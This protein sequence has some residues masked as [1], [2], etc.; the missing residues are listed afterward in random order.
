MARKRQGASLPMI[1]F[2]EILRLYEHGCNQSEIARSCLISR[3]AVRDYLKRAQQCRLSYEQLSSLSDSDIQQL[4]GKG[5]RQ[6]SCSKPAID[7]ESIHRELQHKGVTLAL[8]WM[9]GK[10]RGDW[11]YSYSGFCR[12]YRKWRAQQPV[13]MRQVHK[14]GDKLFVDFCGLTV[15]VKAPK[16]GQ[17]IEAEIFVGCLGASNYT[18]AEAV[19]SQALEHWIGAHQRLLRFFGGVPNKIVPDNLKS[20]VNDPCRYEPGINRTYAEFAEHYDVVVL[21]ARPRAPRDKAK[22]EKA[23]QEVERQILAPLRH[24]SFSSFSALNAA[25]SERLERL[26]DRVMRSYGVSR[27]ALFEELDQP[28]LKALPAQTFEYATWKKAKVSFD[29]HIEVARHYYSVPYA[30]IRKSVMVKISESLIEVFY[31]NQ[32][33]CV[34]ERSSTPFQHSTHDEHMPPEHY[35]YKTQSREKYLVWAAQVGPET[36]A[37]VDAIFDKKQY[38]EQAFR[39]LQGVKHLA[40]TYGAVRLEA[41]CKKANILGIASQ[42]RLSS[43]LKSGLESEPLP[44]QSPQLV[45]ITHANV[46]GPDYYQSS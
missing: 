10:E 12:R 4:L 15:M 28:V 38:D 32:R 19:P 21:P 40:M 27:R 5:K 33:I 37:Q 26:N 43:M 20:G 6:V 11:H 17:E 35:A 42:R 2:R 25:I 1:K 14:G 31:E 23:V 34:H 8:L 46:R 3:T 9:E 29:Y 7:F 39:A 16:T 45:P 18:Y 30:Y 36:T 44:E 24:E 13:S 41:A 22:V